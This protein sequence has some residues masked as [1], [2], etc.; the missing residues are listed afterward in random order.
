MSEIEI[1]RKTEREKERERDKERER[2]IE[3]ETKREKERK[4]ERVRR[5]NYCPPIVQL[6]LLPGQS[7]SNVRNLNNSRIIN[8]GSASNFQAQSE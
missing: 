3:R 8:L 1:E 7:A 6:I 4:R 5:L 2:K